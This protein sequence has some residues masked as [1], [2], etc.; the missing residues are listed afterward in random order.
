MIFSS[1]ESSIRTH[2]LNRYPP[3]DTLSRQA[4]V[5]DPVGGH[6]LRKELDMK[7]VHVLHAHLH[8]DHVTGAGTLK[9]VIEAGTGPGTHAGQA[10][11]IN[12]AKMAISVNRRSGKVDG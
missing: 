9:P 3:G 1:A 4:I 10:P 2:L 12:S 5:V 11:S 7:V 6:A 8:A